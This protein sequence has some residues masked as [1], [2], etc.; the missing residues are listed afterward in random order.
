MPYHPRKSV[1]FNPF[2]AE[3]ASQHFTLPQSSIK[4][5]TKGT[6]FLN[7]ESL[8]NVLEFDVDINE[9]FH[10][11]WDKIISLRSRF[12]S[13]PLLSISQA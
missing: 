4:S 11:L 7:N 3:T 10:I 13:P 9:L 1:G 2:S 12:I 5:F 6:P 8:S